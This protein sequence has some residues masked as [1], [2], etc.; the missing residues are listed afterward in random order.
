LESAASDPDLL[1]LARAGDHQAWTALARRHAPMLAAYLGA[2][3]RRPAVVDQLV[4]E[5]VYAGWRHLAESEAER[6]FP[7]WL[8][9]LAGGVAQRWVQEHPD[10]IAPLPFDPARLPAAA[11]VDA[12]A[13][14]ELDAVIG[15]LDE[16]ERMAL[17]LRWRGGL[18]GPA[19][20]EAL[21]L[22]VAEAEALA[23]RAES[24]LESTDGA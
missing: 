2:R 24:R 3:L 1:R 19:L 6:A 4:A 20:A 14:A 13:V 23:D 15:R 18:A 16:R 12:G 5:T 7:V 9:R 21:H 17:E 8:R 22:P 10:G 11:A